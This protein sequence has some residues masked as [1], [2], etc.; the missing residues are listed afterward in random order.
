MANNALQAVTTAVVRVGR[1][2]STF[3]LYA[4]RVDLNTVGQSNQ[5]LTQLVNDDI[6]LAEL[7]IQAALDHVWGENLTSLDFALDEVR[8]ARLAYFSPVADSAAQAYG[9]IRSASGFLQTAICRLAT[10]SPASPTE[11]N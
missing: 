1:L 3:E 9:H 5:R 4:K 11:L 6:H 7:G 2:L 8:K 10:E